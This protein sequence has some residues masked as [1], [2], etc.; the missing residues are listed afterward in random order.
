MLMADSLIRDAAEID[1]PSIVELNDAEVRHTSPMDIGRLRELDQLASYHKVVVVEGKIAA[2]LLA[3]A[4]NSSYKNENYEWFSFR[5]NK[6][7][8][9]DRIVVGARFAGLGI[10]S[11][12]YRDIFQYARSRNTPA[13]TCEY[14]LVPPNEPS[15]LFHDK[16]GFSEV[17]SQWLANNT[18]KVSLQAARV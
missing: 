16:F 5:Y 13:I 6:F 11:K 8:Y 2:F 9:V 18:K 14:N 4:E 1:Y 15:R 7:L 3:M 12:L 17:G 10:G